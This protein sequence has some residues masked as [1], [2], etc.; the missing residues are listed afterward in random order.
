MRHINGVYTQRYNKLKRTDGPLFRGRYKA[1]LVEAD[2][3]LLQLSRYIHRN[4]IEMKWPLVTSL[5]QYP[6]SSYCAFINEAEPPKWLAREMTYK[7]L[8]DHECYKGYKR[9]V[10]QG[11]SKDVVDFYR[12]NLGQILGSDTYKAFICEQFLADAAIRTVSQERRPDLTIDEVVNS[13]A[14]FYGVDATSLYLSIR[15]L[16]EENEGRKVAMYL[17]QEMLDSRLVS[18]SHVFNLSHPGSVSYVTSKV[19][20]RMLN[21]IKFALRVNRLRRQIIDQAT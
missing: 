21:D 9:F 8:G 15:G 16:S 2:E 6:W 10:L 12:H 13:V 3:Y 5:D 18:L 20:Q 17:C 11:N 4:P 1:I 19:R 7:M 14:D